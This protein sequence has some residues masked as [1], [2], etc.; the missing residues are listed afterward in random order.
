MSLPNTEKQTAGQITSLP[1]LAVNT[2]AEWTASE[3]I[4][5]LRS[6][7]VTAAQYMQACL[8]RI[9]QLEPRLHAWHIYDPDLA[10]QRAAELD[11]KFDAG[12]PLKAMQGVPLG[13]KD[14]YNTYDFPT[15]MGST[16]MDGYTPGNDARLVSDI[17]LEAGIV[18]G[19]TETAE[20]AVHHPGPTIHPLDQ[21][22]SPGTSSS[23][24]AVAV[25]S[26][27][28]PVALA[29]QTA[30]SIIRPASYCGIYGFK[31]SF[32]LLPRTGVLKTTDTLDSLGFMARSIDDLRLL[33]EVCR[34]RGHNYPISETAL[35]DETR[36]TVANRPWKI[37]VVAGPKTEFET[38]EARA[39]L[40]AAVAKLAAAG[41]EIVD[42]RLP[43]EFDEAHDMHERI[44]SRALAYYFDLEWKAD[45]SLFSETMQNMIESGR[46][47]DPAQ[48][49]KDVQ[50]QSALSR[51]IDKAAAEVDILIGLSTA[52]EAPTGLY[53]GD[54]PDHCLIWTACGMPAISIPALKGRENLPV[55]IQIVSR[56]YNDYLLLKFADHL[57]AVLT[58]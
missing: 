51:Q 52:G 18:V 3:Y 41:C 6:R 34:V 27:M 49:Q 37:G 8:D 57:Q 33:F 20:F 29:S 42:F 10:L 53:S 50:L 46:A 40:D 47:V 35:N 58:A 39:G 14:I 17:R 16:I 21:A 23:G 9:E 4:D 11:A 55:G 31:P 15:G 24:S 5:M 28:V 32:G 45:Q 2:V 13:V 54:L 22:R 43:A 1:E 30:G 12:T 38:A 48:Y 56:R 7:Q 26:R 25:A 44:Y 19:K 36:Q